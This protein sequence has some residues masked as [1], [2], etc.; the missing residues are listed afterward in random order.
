MAYI[1]RNNWL[2]LLFFACLGF[3]IYANS[4]EVP[5]LFDDAR[6]IQHSSLQFKELSVENIIKSGTKGELTTRPIANISFAFN[7]LI[8]GDNLKSYHLFNILIHILSSIFLFHLFYLTLTL[9]SLNTEAHTAKIIS[10]F[11]ALLWLVNPLHS[12]SVTYLVQRMNSMATMFY[13][14]SLLCYVLGRRKMIRT[15]LSQRKEEKTEKSEKKR[16]WYWF[17]ASLFSGLLAIGSKEIAVTLPFFI[18]LYEWY[19]VQ[20]LNKKWLAKQKIWLLTAGILLTAMAFFYMNGHP[21]KYIMRAYEVRDFTLPERLLTQLRVVIHYI[22]LII[23]P[24]PARLTFDYNFPLSTS[25]IQP[26]STLFSFLTLTCLV[27]VSVLAAQKQRLLSFC[28]IWFLGNL[29]IESSVIGLEMIFEH[30][31]YLPSTFLTLFFVWLVL[32]NDKIRTRGM[33]IIGVISIV[34]SLWTWERNKVY[35][36]PVS[37]WQDSVSKYPGKARSHNNLGKSLYESGELEKSANHYTK[38]LEIDPDYFLAHNNL[39]L[40]FHKLGKPTLAEQYYRQALSIEKR[41]VAARYNL[42]ILL[43]SQGKVAEAIQQHHLALKTAPES[44]LVNK[45]L[46]N[47]LLQQNKAGEALQHFDNAL[48]RRPEDIETL[49]AAAMANLQIGKKKAALQMYQKITGLDKNDKGAHFNMALLFTEQNE[50]TKALE[51]YEKVLSIDKTFVPALYNKAN[52][53]FKQNRFEE[54]KK[55]YQVLLKRVPNDINVHNNL[56]MTLLKKG[57]LELAEKQFLHVL[58]LNPAHQLAKNNLKRIQSKREQDEN[59]KR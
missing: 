38:A 42:A 13:L 57:E 22:T 20:D 1:F 7:Y 53:L 24:S 27:G 52:L 19:F 21:V 48:Q 26:V 54:A 36:N 23:Y 59:L 8:S 33:V 9:P 11:S 56:G 30:R 5:F 31:T 43:K 46:G 25:L 12:Q 18:L 47:L 4:L 3:G 29:V 49:H 58:S 28:I 32:K 40:C 51:Q 15:T 10:L 39:A 37:F 35:Q 16:A 17:G 41:Y 55:T 2:V 14:L 45:S 6:N 44:F 50:F 34:F